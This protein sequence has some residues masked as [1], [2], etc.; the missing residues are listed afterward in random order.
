MA[1]LFNP[2]R[3][4]PVA[5]SNLLELITTTA[6]VAAMIGDARVLPI[7]ADGIGVFDISDISA[8]TALI[9][10][11]P[12]KRLNIT[13]AAG[14]WFVFFVPAYDFE[15]INE[16][17]FT[18]DNATEVDP[19]TLYA[20]IGSTGAIIRMF[21]DETVDDPSGTSETTSPAS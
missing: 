4:V 17:D 3:I 6:N 10:N 16:G 2:N 9:C 19:S 18:F 20:I 7:T 15:S 11:E 1:Q 21:D 12:V 5:A 13:A 8:G 14:N